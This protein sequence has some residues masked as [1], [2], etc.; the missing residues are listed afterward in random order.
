MST[1]A[2]DWQLHAMDG[3]RSTCI[4]VDEAHGRVLVGTTEGYWFGEAATG[5]WESRIMAGWI[6]REV[7]SIIGHPTHDERVVTGRVNAFFKGYIELTD[8]LAIQGTVIHESNG[9]KVNGLAGTPGH[10]DRI[11]ACTWSDVVDGEALRS[12]DG[13]ATWHLLGNALHHAMTSVSV[14]ADG[15]VFV[16]GDGLVT[17]S[18]DLGATWAT[19]ATGLPPT[20]GV[21]AVAASPA[22]AGRLLACNDSG[23]W[24]STDS[25]D[26]W[27]QID[28]RSCRAISWGWSCVSGGPDHELAAVVTWTDRVLLSTDGGVSFSDITSDLAPAVPVDA[29][30]SSRDE[31]LYA[32]TLDDGVWSTRMCAPVL[33]ADGFES[34]TT[35]RWSA[36]VP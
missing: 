30:F 32:A 25:G 23:L 5:A 15:T 35:S 22:V 28:A 19:A 7:G 10:A 20:E 27:T 6:G 21:Y 26:G 1:W 2:A 16:S 14:G 31:A 29:S 8:S 33:F 34:G 13:G 12:D 4:A 9:G 3:E 24:R 11:Y 18:S 17:R 36:T